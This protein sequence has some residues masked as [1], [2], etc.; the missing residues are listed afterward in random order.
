[1]HTDWKTTFAAQMRGFQERRPPQP[2]EIAVSIKLRVLSGCF[3]R[4]HSPHAYAIIDKQLSTVLDAESGAAFEEHET[5]P[6]LFVYIALGTAGITLAKSVIDLI[7]TVIKARSESTARGDAPSSPVELVV[8]R[9]SERGQFREE[10]VVKFSL[11]EPVSTDRIAS[12]L[13]EALE[14]IVV[15]D[16]SDQGHGQQPPRKETVPKRSRR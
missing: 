4:E 7:T 16:S 12:C 10:V 1:M 6:E 8:R 2:G 5:G 14:R 11:G 13:S 15:K 3:H 9:V